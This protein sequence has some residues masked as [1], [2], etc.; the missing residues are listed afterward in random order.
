MSDRKD[1]QDQDNAQPLAEPGEKMPT[2]GGGRSGD[3]PPGPPAVPTNDRYSRWFGIVVILIAFVGLGGWASTAAIDSAV[4]AQGTV[5]VDSYRQSVEHLEGGIVQSIEV[6]SGDVVERGDLL[7]QLDETEARSEY[8]I[9]NSRLLSELARRARLQAEIDGAE[10]IDFPKQVVRHAEDSDRAAAVIRTQRRQF[11][12]R[13]EALQGEIETLEQRTKRQ[14]ERIDGMKAQLASHERAIKSLKQEL[15]SNRRLGERDLIPS[16]ELRPIERKLADEEGRAG[17]LRARIASTWI[18]I[19]ETEQQIVQRR[20]EFQRKVAA[21]LREANDRI[22]SLKEELTALEDRLRRK[23]IRAPVAGEVVNLRVHSEQAVIQAGE[24]VLD[25]VPKGEPLVIDSRVRPQDIDSVHVGQ[26]ADVRLT[27]FSF[28][29]TPVVVGEIIRLS[30]DALEDEQSGKSYYRARVEV[31]QGE[32]DKLGGKTLRPGMPADVMITTGERTP[33]EYL[34]KPLT[35][36]L[37]RAF[38]EE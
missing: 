37:A 16:A 2:S 9:K 10:T 18:E 35:D 3:A 27:A 34:L 23:Q 33:M 28:R 13:R 31:A 11:K 30:A 14:R 21:A 24:P 7:I 38:V 20:R 8:E 6:T 32:L 12:T 1:E 36:G 17:E 5:T 26:S 19:Q 29:T 4:V 25:I 15:E 22:A